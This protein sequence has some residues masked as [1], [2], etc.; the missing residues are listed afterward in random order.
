VKFL[1]VSGD[2]AR[3]VYAFWQGT[4]MRSPEFREKIGGRQSLVSS[5]PKRRYVFENPGFA[6]NNRMAR[7]QAR[8]ITENG[9]DGLSDM[10]H[11][12]SCA[13]CNS[14]GLLRSEVCNIFEWWLVYIVIPY[15]CRVCLHRQFRWRFIRISPADPHAHKPT[16]GG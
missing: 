2:G 4:K 12:H 5:R 11:C 15:R 13:K 10:L 14:T 7:I 8:R 1:R 9:I 6:R 3:S 16:P